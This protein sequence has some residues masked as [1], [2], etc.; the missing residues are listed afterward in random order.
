MKYCYII[1]I[2]Y[3][4][5]FSITPIEYTQVLYILIK[6]AKIKVIFQV[7][8]LLEVILKSTNILY[9]WENVSKVIFI[10]KK[11]F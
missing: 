6:N 11:I 7:I 3:F 2:Y 1:I 10:S 4:G 9:N 8:C 5:Q